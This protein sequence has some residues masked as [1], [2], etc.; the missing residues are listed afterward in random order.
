ML[1]SRDR[2]GAARTLILWFFGAMAATAQ[3]VAALHPI[4]RFPIRHDPLS[5]LRPVQPA[6]PFTVPG[7]RSGIFGEQNGAFEAWLYPVKILSQFSMT[8]ELADYPVPI[9]VSTY[10]AT[11]DVSPAITT[12]TYSHAA[13]TIRQRMF[14]ARGDSPGLAIV[15]EIASTRPMTLTFR[16]RPDMQR[17]WPAPNYGPPNP[18]WVKQGD[19][20]YY[21][22]H[23]DNADV[24]AAV[25]LPRA[26]PGV[27]AP[28]QERPKTYPVELKLSFDPKRDSELV[29]PFLI[30]SGGRNF[31][32]ARELASLNQNV[33]RIYRETDQY[34]EHFFDSRLTSKT[35]NARFDE[36]LR[37]AQIAIDQGRVNQ[38]REPGLVAGYYGSGDSA[39]P[40]FAWYFGRDSLF[41]SWAANS[42]GDFALTRLI[43]EFLIHRQRSDGKIMHEYSQTAGLPETNW[44]QT[45]YFYA[46]ADSTPLFIM[47]FEDYVNASGD[48]GYLRANWNELKRAWAFTRAHDSDRDGIYENTEGSGWVESWPPGMP[49]QEIYLAALDQQSA[50]AM[51]R[52]AALMAESDLAA[53]ARQQAEIIRTKI[54]S[55]YYEPDRQFYAF[56]RN[57]DGSLDHTAT[58]FPS[59]AWWS[60]RFSLAHPETMLDRWASAEFSTDWGIRDV[61]DRTDFYDPIS[62]HQG[63]VW[64]LYTGWAA[65]A[66]YRAGRPLSA[67]THLMQNVNLTWAQDPGAVTELLSG[68]FFQPLGRSSSHQIWSSAMVLTPALRGLFGLDLDALNHTVRVAPHLPAMWDQA[69]LH[70]VPLAGI[71]M[72]VE[73]KRES[74]GLTIR[75]KTSMPE[76]ICLVPEAF[77]RDR[78]CGSPPAILHQ[79][80][81]PLQPVE[82]GLPSE[83]PQPGAMTSQLKVISERASATQFTVILE[84]PASSTLDLP[85]RMNRPNVRVSGAAIAGTNLHVEM[86]RGNGYKRLTVTF[87]W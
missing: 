50:D 6:K 23:T 51:S 5:I 65:I 17:M 13:F 77:E 20:G 39:R 18:E 79:L 11:I 2:M 38:G 9:D 67:Y 57:T 85:L 64:P 49:H 10:A 63:S 19:S 71:R 33:P 58:A 46:A 34:Y 12:I 25:A 41:T 82:I 83:P 31:Q 1:L 21:V 30:V 61:S 40:G 29:F 80:Q 28:Y 66:E 86:P 3:P 73:F 62:Y 56:S 74:G 45:P 76:V 42:Y 47:A 32:P 68:Q 52:L 72:D 26:Q 75:A 81:L 16:F 48:M 59:I 84:A 8:A 15:F 44:A 22:L 35:P 7:E 4:E 70:N 55:E 69:E 60:G 78:N 87:A 27:L 43:F 24:V 36:A 37:W 54:E 14:A 53:T